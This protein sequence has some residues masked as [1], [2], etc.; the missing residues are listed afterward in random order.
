MVSVALGFPAL[1]KWPDAA[2]DETIA[3]KAMSKIY[4]NLHRP[5][6]GFVLNTGI[7][8][9]IAMIDWR[10]GGPIRPCNVSADDNTFNQLKNHLTAE[11]VSWSKRYTNVIINPV[12]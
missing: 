9:G 7:T 5:L 2:K 12:R 3:T 8:V 10:L 1:V 6:N 4:N 11:P